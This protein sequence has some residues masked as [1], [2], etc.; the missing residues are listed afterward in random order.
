[1]E[2]IC[3]SGANKARQTADAHF[4]HAAK[5]LGL[6]DPV[7][8]FMKTPFRSIRVTIPLTMDDGIHQLFVGYR[9][10]HNDLHTPT[11]GG[12]RYHPTVDENELG[13]L[14]ENMTWRAALV[15]IPV[16][17]AMGG[18][19]CDPKVL[20]KWELRRITQ[21]YIA[22]IHHILGPHSDIPAPDVNTNS[23]VM[24]WILQEYGLRHGHN[25]ACVTGKPGYL[26]GLMDPHKA[27]S[28]GAAIVLSKHLSD[29]GHSLNGMEVVVQGFGSVGSTLALELAERGCEIVAVS[30]IDSGIANKNGGGLQV[31]KLIKHVEETGS[32]SNF[33]GARTTDREKVLSLE[34]D[35]LVT[36]AMECAIHE[37]NADEI[38]ASIIAEAANLPTSFEA[39]AKLERKGITVLPDILT[40]AGAAIC[41]YFEWKQNLHATSTQDG[42]PDMELFRRLTQSY[43][44]MRGYASAENI[45][46]KKAAYAIALERI[47]ADEAKHI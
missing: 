12:I 40:N 47:A 39:D 14:A 6:G 10:Q 18:V 2:T 20:S 44:D 37:N 33:P 3:I 15:R 24:S 45:S 32:V 34:C 7:K 42:S 9:I 4:A 8:A 26:E 43:E 30:D 38:K 27:A 23:E 21:K 36:A 25:F 5:A 41:S 11:M 17:G 46:F 31:P 1:M 19:R 13:A 29:H 28:K 22:R 16:G 35:I